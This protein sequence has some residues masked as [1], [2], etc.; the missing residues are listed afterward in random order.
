MHCLYILTS[1]A[2]Y[3]DCNLNANCKLV[4]FWI[5]VLAFD[6]FCSSVILGCY[7]LYGRQRISSSKTLPPEHY[8]S[9]EIYFYQRF[10]V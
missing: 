2:S 8:A 1:K 7:T 9:R 5:F 6:V 10:Y 4:F 3:S